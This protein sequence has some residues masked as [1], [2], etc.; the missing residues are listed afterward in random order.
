MRKRVF[1]RWCVALTALWVFAN[2]PTASGLGGLWQHAGFSFVFAWGAFGRF[3]HFD[4]LL[5]L[6]DCL[7][8]ILVVVGVSWLCAW[9]RWYPDEPGKEA[10]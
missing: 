2:W 8:G 9:S 6:L 1:T 7:L 10:G 4:F 5:L 3:E